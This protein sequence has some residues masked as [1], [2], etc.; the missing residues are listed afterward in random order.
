VKQIE[1]GRFKVL[2]TWIDPKTGRRVYR[3]QIVE[4]TQDDALRARGELRRETSSGAP[5]RPRF[6]AFADA[7]LSRRKKNLQ[8]STYDRYLHDVAHLNLTFGEWW[9]DA[10]DYDAIERWQAEAPYAP[11][12]V[13]GWHR[14]MRLI[15]D[16]AVRRGLLRTNPAREL[17]VL[18]EGRTKGARGTALS[19]GELK[20]FVAAISD[21]EGV[22]SDVARAMHVL[23]WTG[24]R[25]G[26]VIALRWD[27]IV[28][29]EFH[30]ERSVWRG[31]EK[32]TKTDDPRRITIVAPLLAI[33]EEQRRW[34]LTEQHPGLASGLIFPAAPTQ[35]AAGASRRAKAG[36]GEETLWFRSQSTLQEAVRAVCQAAGT[37]RVTP[38]SLRRT[39]E[40]LLREAGVE[41]LV[42][43]AVAGWRSDR[44][45]GIY[46]T[47]RREDRD[48]AA[49][50]VI[51]LVLG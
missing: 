29:G 36:R 44:A 32:T 31:H 20:A 24:C 23:A 26:E 41:Q 1:D 19:A 33:I 5:S 9:V 14:T 38:H 16:G 4:G 34:L 15:L 25:I 27:D 47:V 42:R 18:A 35:A 37:P 40:D 21:V 39:F 7:W 43:R 17:P 12:T 8:P 3:R 51:R 22:S 6:R 2:K 50:A 28:H 11:P 30:I 46:A 10:V 49:S 45:Q 13:N 48:A